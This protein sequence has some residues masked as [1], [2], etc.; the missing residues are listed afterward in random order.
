MPIVPSLPSAGEAAWR[1]IG[2]CLR[3][4]QATMFVP[5][6]LFLAALAAMLLRH[7]DVP[8]YE[9]DRVAFVVLVLGVSGRAILT[10]QKLLVVGRV[11]WPMIGLII[12]GKTSSNLPKTPTSSKIRI[13]HTGRDSRPFLFTIGISF[14]IWFWLGQLTAASDLTGRSTRRTQHSWKTRFS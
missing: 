8:F 4:V 3:P 11:T 7:P 6:A 10:R 2:M 13:Q 5:T 12:L 1:G 14:Q 9:V